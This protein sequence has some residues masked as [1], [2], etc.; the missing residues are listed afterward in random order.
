MVSVKCVSKEWNTLVDPFLK[1]AELNEFTHFVDYIQNGTQFNIR[2]ITVEK[3]MDGDDSIEYRIQMDNLCTIVFPD[4]VIY[5]KGNQTLQNILGEKTTRLFMGDRVRKI[6]KD[7]YDSVIS[8]RIIRRCNIDYILIYLPNLNLITEHYFKPILRFY[9]STEMES[10]DRDYFLSGTK[11]SDGLVKVIH[12]SDGKICLLIGSGYSYNYTNE[13]KFIMNSG[14]LERVVNIDGKLDGLK[15]TRDLMIN[16]MTSNGII[17]EFSFKTG[18][19]YRLNED[20]NN[21][22]RKYIQ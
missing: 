8:G 5:L 12:K 19:I 21:K 15:V 2:T 10:L 14:Q 4:T 17:S 6:Y 1:E 13:E 11:Y 22:K 9:M 3:S 18:D 7:N 20:I 16:L